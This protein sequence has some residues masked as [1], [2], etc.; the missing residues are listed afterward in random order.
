MTGLLNDCGGGQIFIEWFVNHNLGA[1]PQFVAHLYIYK[2]GLYVDGHHT[3]GIFR[4]KSNVVSN[5]MLNKE[6]K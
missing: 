5:H 4:S 6:V 2:D 3:T 1:S